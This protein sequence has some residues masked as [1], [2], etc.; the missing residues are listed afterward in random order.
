MKFET[1]LRLALETSQ[2]ERE[3]TPDLEAGY[4]RSAKS[5]ELIVKYSG[6]LDGLRQEGVIV[7][8]LIAGYAIVTIPEDKVEL[9][10]QMPE[11]EYVEKP[12]AFY[13]SNI[14]P[15]ESGCVTQLTSREPFLSGENVLVAIIDSGIKYDLPMFLKENG[16]TRIEA[17]WDQSI[18]REQVSDEAQELPGPPEGFFIGAEFDREH[19]NR[20]LRETNPGRKYALLPSVD[21]SGHGTAVAGIVA[22]YEKNRYEG[23][24]GKASLLIIKMAP[25][26]AEGFPGTTQIMR[27]V[28]YALRKARMLG[29]PLVINLSFGNNYGSHQGDSLLERFLDNASEIGKTA[30][31]V[32]SGNEGRGFGHCVTNLHTD[33]EVAFT[34]ASYEPHLSL[35][36]WKSALDECS[37]SVENPGGKTAFLVPDRQGGKYSFLLGK[38]K[39][40]VCFGESSPYSLRQEIYLEFLPIQGFYLESGIWRINISTDKIV[41]G[42]MDSYLPSR[43][44]RNQGTGFVI[45]AS[46]MTLTIPSTAAR[47]ITVGAFDERYE[48][49]AVFSG[50]GYKLF[51]GIGSSF[52]IPV[53][54]DVVAPGVEVI[55]PG[56]TG[57]LT[58]VTGTSF[59]TP[60][61][62]GIAALLMEWGIVRKQDLFLYGDKL[63]ATLR[64]GCVSLRGERN[65]PNERVGFGNVCGEYL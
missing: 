12:K 38:T 44:V 30:I 64:S 27:G 43:A 8:E 28:V 16:D 41:E 40:L 46:D 29:V 48:S 13:Y 7:E 42:R 63:K 6:S 36:I 32:G 18:K 33:R 19:I 37:F 11:I 22:G 45:P 14:G 51:E 9:L 49:F 17:I 53:K 50:R 31:C 5:W 62:S 56:T 47:V 20:A 4:N 52:Q 55:A 59:S 57:Q 2:N 26:S 1:A 15:T 61:V 65:Y 23:I 10:E 35:Q 39:L 25:I 3:Q 21:T 58:T 24:A 60:I 54:P 34:V